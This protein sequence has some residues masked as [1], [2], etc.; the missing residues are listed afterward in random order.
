MKVTFITFP[1]HN[2]VHLSRNTNVGDS[3]E[4]LLRQ[5]S[6]AFIQSFY[7]FLDILLHSLQSQSIILSMKPL[8]FTQCIY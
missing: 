8:G 1:K 3:L 6:K 4:L 7:D 2:P 5:G